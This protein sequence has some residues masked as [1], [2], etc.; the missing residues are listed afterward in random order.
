MSPE[1]LALRYDGA[2]YWD[3]A[4]AELRRLLREAID[5]KG[6]KQVAFDLD[7]APSALLHAIDER[8]RHH[9][10]AS[11]I[12]YLVANASNDDLAD[13]FAG[14]RGRETIPAKPVLPE[15]EN[16]AI[17]EALERHLGPELRAAI[18]ATARK[19]LRR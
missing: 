1:Q 11:W 9:F 7:V 8:E 14:L 19:H 17:K 3:S 2:G 15:E 12:P 5:F 18:L 6:L 13:F 16:A 4:W 10:R